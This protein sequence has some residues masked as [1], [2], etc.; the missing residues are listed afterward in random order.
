[1]E[2]LA[3]AGLDPFPTCVGMNRVGIISRGRNPPVPYMRGDEPH[4]RVVFI[5]S[6]IPFP[7]CVGMN[8]STPDRAPGRCPVPYMRGDEPSVLA[9]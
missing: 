5:A 7:T 2:S 6:E 4:L 9:I 3:A 1:M 8:R